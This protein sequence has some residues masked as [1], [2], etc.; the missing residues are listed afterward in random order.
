M[1]TLSLPGLAH[2]TLPDRVP[3]MDDRIDLAAWTA[4]ANETAFAQIVERH[5]GLVAAV[6]R[7]QLGNGAA[8][9]EAVQAVFIILARRAQAVRPEALRSWLYETA[10][11]VCRNARRAAAR[12][13]R[14][15]Q[16]AAVSAT[17]AQHHDDEVPWMELRPRIDEALGS[18]N[19]NQRS[20]IIDHFFIGES[21]VAIAARLGISED[22]LAGWSR[23]ARY[24]PVTRDHPCR[25]SP[26]TSSTSPANAC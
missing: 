11:G 26:S 22:A 4:S 8:V 24:A 19:A 10:I 18:L 1:D 12:R 6:C 5:A 21:Q 9:D 23:S 20:V 13:S 17:L 7:R 16:E 15:E 3:M 2:P 25:N 14:H